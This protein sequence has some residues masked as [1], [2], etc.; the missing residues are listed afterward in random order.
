MVS[1]YRD[2]RWDEKFESFK[3]SKEKRRQFEEKKAEAPVFSSSLKKE[4]PIYAS[5]LNK[6][7]SRFLR[8]QVANQQKRE[9]LV[10]TQSTSQISAEAQEQPK[11]QII[12]SE[13]TEKEKRESS[14]N[15]FP[16]ILIALGI[17]VIVLVLTKTI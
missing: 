3:R 14:T 16:F 5:K 12:T 15:W 9:N 2:K 4:E 13:P 11:V 10:Q 17:I 7:P 6:G 1:E 8:T